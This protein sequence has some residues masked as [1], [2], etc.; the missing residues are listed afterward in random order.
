M[1]PEGNPSCGGKSQARCK[2]AEPGVALAARNAS[3][4]REK[5]RRARDG[6]GRQSHACFAQPGSRRYDPIRR[7]EQHVPAQH[8][9]RSSNARQC[10]D[11]VLLQAL[12]RALVTRTKDLVTL[13]GLCV[14]SLR[15]DHANL[16]CIVPMLTD[17]P[18][19]ESTRTL[20]HIT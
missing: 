7:R 5:K 13:L 15:R 2:S 16:L 9:T 18:R 10:I 8:G 17:D 12:R 6:H 20:P 11:K 19:R 14:S 3:R 4:P 1:I